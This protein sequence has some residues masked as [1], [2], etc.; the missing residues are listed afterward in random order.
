MGERSLTSL[1]I[2]QREP[3]RCAELIQQ[4]LDEIG[5]L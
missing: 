4:F 2:L 3:K 1:L 5:Q